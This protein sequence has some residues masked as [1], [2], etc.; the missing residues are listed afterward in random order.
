MARQRSQSLPTPTNDYWTAARSPLCCL[1]FLLPLLVCYEVG[2]LWLGGSNP[3]AIR[4]GADYWMRAW[5]EQQGYQMPWL[6]P[7]LVVGC[8]MAWHVTGQFPW[9]VKFETLVGMAAESVLFACL[10]LLLAQ[11]QDWL[12]R[13]YLD[14][15]ELAL[16]SMHLN[17]EALQR[18]ISF[19]G[20]GIYEEVLFR[21]LAIPIGQVLFR[22]LLVPQRYTLAASILA[23]SL[24]FSS[25]H[26]WGPAADTLTL[27]SFVFR[28]I[29]GLFFAIL[30][31]LRGF[32]ITVG[33]HAGYDVMV[34]ILLS[35]SA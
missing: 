19:L 8:L 21:L 4:N 1:I 12:F 24:L 31:V 11:G 34:G 9:R 13:L 5:L 23:T 2:I 6:L 17:Q 35:S 22:A 32:G 14:P 16:V 18:T 30:F 7:T 10:L 25:A 26:Y 27:F 3:E 20:A 33:A 29:A 28:T 15:V